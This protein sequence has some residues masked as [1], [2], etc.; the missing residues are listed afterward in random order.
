MCTSRDSARTLLKSNF[1]IITVGC[2]FCIYRERALALT[3]CA[4][5]HLE[6]CGGALEEGPEYRTTLTTIVLDILELG[7]NAGAPCY[8]ARYPD[9]RIQVMLSKIAQ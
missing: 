3:L 2:L 7:E 8:Y 9:K 5:V 1:L 4:A 6:L